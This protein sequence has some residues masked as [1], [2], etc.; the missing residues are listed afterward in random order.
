MS[1]LKG[2]Y[3]GERTPTLAYLKRGLK[4]WVGLEQMSLKQL[5]TLRILI[6][7]QGCTYMWRYVWDFRM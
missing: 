3:S 1:V 7:C 5:L 6:L 4:P 2:L